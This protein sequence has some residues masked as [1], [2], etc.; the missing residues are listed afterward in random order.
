MGLV[1]VAM[2]CG[3][4]YL[5][6]VEK[7]AHYAQETQARLMQTAEGMAADALLWLASGADA[8]GCVELASAQP[9]SILQ[10]RGLAIP[11]ALW[12]FPP[13]GK[14]EGPTG[15]GALAPGFAPALALELA[16]PAVLT[17]DKGERVE[18]LLTA[19][20]RPANAGEHRAG[21]VEL[22]ALPT[23]ALRHMLASRQGPC[24]RGVVQIPTHAG[25]VLFY[26]SPPSAVLR[27]LLEQAGPVAPVAGMSAPSVMSGPSVANA[28]TAAGTGS[29][30]AQSSLAVA[31][32]GEVS[33]QAGFESICS[34]PTNTQ[35]FTSLPPWF[36][37]GQGL[38]VVMALSLTVLLWRKAR[39]L[40]PPA[41]HGEEG[42]APAT[43]DDTN[44]ALTQQVRAERARR[45][46][47][48]AQLITLLEGVRCSI[49]RELHDH[50]GQRLT[51]VLLALE[52]AQSIQNQSGPVQNPQTSSSLLEHTAHELR[53]IHEEL[54]DIA[55]GLRPPA[56]DMLGLEAAL[57][58]LCGECA[59]PVGQE[60]EPGL[61]VRF[62]A[63]SVPPLYGDKGLALYRV[64]QEALHNAVK[65]A[66]A[67]QVF[68]SLT[69][70]GKAL[71]LT[72]EDN[73]RGFAAGDPAAPA[74]ADYSAESVSSLPQTGAPPGEQAD[75]Q[76]GAQT[77]AHTG[78]GLLL[79][80]ERMAQWGGTLHVESTPGRGTVVMAE[81][82]ID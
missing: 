61:E 54:R 35:S 2:Q 36:W 52:S 17:T 51:A 82:P 41:A 15:Q 71:T 66:Q 28:A 63:D 79:M 43:A 53:G 27:Q 62:F 75:T 50:T 14:P 7:Q 11:S 59:I 6:A 77:F 81:L 8:V 74:A 65:H 33:V 9:H 44:A 72:V 20:R 57:R 58:A 23:A 76:T 48:S 13:V 29:D 70:R 60:S 19:R 42:D 68:V 78:L 21:S 25:P 67:T 39:T 64:A 16:P 26:T 40:P 32:L 47:L 69:G 38:A 45:Q 3:W 46:Q 31:D 80:A 10:S 37:A 1:L 4:L 12:F 49:A 56:L 34:S 55:R 73:G 22:R 18:V 30:W 5:Y 24:A